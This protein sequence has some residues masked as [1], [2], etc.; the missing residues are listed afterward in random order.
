MFAKLTGGSFFDISGLALSV[1]ILI[2]F[3]R[4]AFVNMS[5]EELAENDS[6]KAKSA[7]TTLLQSTTVRPELVEGLPRAPDLLQW[8]NH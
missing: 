7:H 4:E 1:G 5:A 8:V 6:V 3:S 2:G